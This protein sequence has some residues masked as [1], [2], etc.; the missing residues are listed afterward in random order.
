MSSTMRK[1]RRKVARYNMEQQDLKLFK[2]YSPVT[3]KIWDKRKQKFVNKDVQRSYF[4]RSW[5]VYC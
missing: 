5:K 2:Q 3:M 4:A 1:L